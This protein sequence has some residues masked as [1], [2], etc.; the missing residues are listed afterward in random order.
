[1]RRRA[2]RAFLRRLILLG[3]L[4]ALA[5]PL[6]SCGKK[7]QPEPPPGSQNTYPRVYPSE[8]T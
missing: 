2:P 1:M 6:V 8:S 5:L 3:V 4:A 7:N